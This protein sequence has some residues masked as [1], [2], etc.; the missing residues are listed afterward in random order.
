MGLFEIQ[1]KTSTCTK[2]IGLLNVEVISEIYN[3]KT[4]DT[5][6]KVEDKT[7]CCVSGCDIEEFF[8]EINKVIDKYRI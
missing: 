8:K 7:L 5:N 1:Q 6:I 4:M 2:Y 3:G